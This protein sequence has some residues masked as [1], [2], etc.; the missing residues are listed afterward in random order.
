MLH[1]FS[2]VKSDGFHAKTRIY[3]VIR[4]MSHKKMGNIALTSNRK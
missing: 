1:L 4:E 3:M 2:H